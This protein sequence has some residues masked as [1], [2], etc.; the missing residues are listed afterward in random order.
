MDKKKKGLP[1]I[2]SSPPQD[3]QNSQQNMGSQDY[4]NLCE[5]FVEQNVYGKAGMFPTAADAI[6]NYSKNGQA[7][8]GTDGIQ[9]GDMVYFAPDQSNGFDGH[10]GIYSGDGK[11]ISATSNGVAE[12]DLN[13]W[14]K[15]TGQQLVG[16]VPP[17]SDTVSP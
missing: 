1:Q 12:Y 10:T 17:P 14:Q 4:N 7:Y 3:V 13:Q 5:K 15:D 9:E 6:N 16:F 2:S 8:T 11:F